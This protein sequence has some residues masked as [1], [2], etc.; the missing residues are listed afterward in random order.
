MSVSQAPPIIPTPPSW[1]EQQQESFS[2]LLS[3]DKSSALLRRRQR[4]RKR[5]LNHDELY[6]D[7]IADWFDYLVNPHLLDDR[8]GRITSESGA[9]EELV[10]LHDLLKQLVVPLDES[11]TPCFEQKQADGDTLQTW[12]MTKKQAG[13]LHIIAEVHF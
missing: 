7:T 9:T 10:A 12:S 4:K 3:V 13:L 8:L 6:E 11:T 2:Q 1:R 5:H